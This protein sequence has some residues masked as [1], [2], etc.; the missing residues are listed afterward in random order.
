MPQCHSDGSNQCPSYSLPTSTLDLPRDNAIFQV[1]QRSLL[2]SFFLRQSNTSIRTPASLE[3]LALRPEEKGRETSRAQQRRGHVAA[4]GPPRP[5]GEGGTPSQDPGC[6]SG[7]MERNSLAQRLVVTRFR[8]MHLFT[9]L[10][11]SLTLEMLMLVG[12]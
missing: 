5:Q 4:H 9:F 12:H 2:A 8:K 3:A 7:V 10:S 6:L 11:Y 1:T